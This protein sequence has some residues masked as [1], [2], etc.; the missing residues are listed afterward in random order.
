MP[1]KSPEH[2]FEL[3]RE[4]F[5]AVW[6]HGGMWITIWYPFVSGQLGRTDATDRLIGHMKDKVGVWFATLE[7]IATN[8]NLQGLIAAGTRKPRCE[9]IPYWTLPVEH[10]VP[11]HPL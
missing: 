8:T 4:E 1:T 11:M 10:L 2:A 5:D 9:R 6:A 3:F 7:E